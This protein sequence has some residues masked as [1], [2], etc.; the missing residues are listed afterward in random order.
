MKIAIISDAIYPY[1]K[2]GKEKRIFD[3]SSGGIGTKL[4]TASAIFIKTTY[5]LLSK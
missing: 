3:P 5:A 2:G 4:K 1:N